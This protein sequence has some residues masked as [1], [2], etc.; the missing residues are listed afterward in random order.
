MTE[1]ERVIFSYLVRSLPF[2]TVLKG[3]V[4]RGAVNFLLNRD[5]RNCYGQDIRSKTIQAFK[6]LFPG[7]NPLWLTLKRFIYQSQEEVKTLS[8]LTESYRKI[9]TFEG[10]ERLPKG[11]AV[12]LSFH[13]LNFSVML[14][15]LAEITGRRIYAVAYNL[16]KDPKVPEETKRYFAFKYSCMLKKLNGGSLIYLDRGLE[17]LKIRRILREGH[18][19]LILCDLPDSRKQ[20]AYSF[21]DHRWYF[22]SGGA[23]LA[24]MCGVPLVPVVVKEEKTT[25]WTV[26]LGPALK[27][28]DFRENMQE[29]LRFLEG[30]V[31]R[32]PWLWYAVDVVLSYRAG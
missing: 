27:G 4:F 32:S 7:R 30:C 22:A 23:R 15:S 2:D 29:A 28:K 9:Y 8:F 24:E 19:V 25:K 20:Y 5:W 14:A 6:F 16:F 26:I 18:L 1:G 17:S 3:A 31:R 10:L 11:G 13:L 21:L 12:L